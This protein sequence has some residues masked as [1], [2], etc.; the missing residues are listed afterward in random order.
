MADFF[1]RHTIEWNLR[2]PHLVRRLALS[3]PVMAI[4]TGIVVRAYRW[5]V[6]S[7]GAMGF[8]S[9]LA[10]IAGGLVL[11]LGLATA[12]LGNHPVRQWVWRAPLF[13]LI[14]SA[15]EAVASAVLLAAGLE[16][17]GTAVARWRDWPTMAFDALEWRTIAVLS[18]ALVLAAVVQW[19]RF[20][21]LKHEHRAS[22]AEAIHQER[23]G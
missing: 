7:S 16:R 13:V 23:E 12:H 1:P 6:L 11:L 19:V 22:M 17:F 3:L 14:E 18:F 10:S 5:M 15:T 2:E 9:V 21:L 20:A 8:W 4:V